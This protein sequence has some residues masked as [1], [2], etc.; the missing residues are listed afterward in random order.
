MLD[1]LKSYNISALF[2]ENL[3]VKSLSAQV[4]VAIHAYGILLALPLILDSDESI[5]YLSLGAGNT[6][7]PYD[8]STTKRVA[9]FKFAKWNKK[10]NVI[11]QNNLFTNF[12]ELAIDKKT[13]T[14]KKYIYCYNSDA[15]TTFLE[16][17]GR[18]LES[19]LSRNS[20]NKKYPAIASKFKTVKSFY[21]Q[22]K[23]EVFIESLEK[24]LGQE[25]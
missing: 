19:V 18:S 6:G 21:E 7:K 1:Y 25:D 15:V 24:I 12:L 5:E 3:F 20:K 2:A 22:Y 16:T 14:R 11:R 4:D 10:N 9:E 17:S 8:V 13:K 23:N